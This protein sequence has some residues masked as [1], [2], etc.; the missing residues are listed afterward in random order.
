VLSRDAKRV[1]KQG[2]DSSLRYEGESDDYGLREDRKVRAPGRITKVIFSYPILFFF[3]IIFSGQFDA[4][5]LS[6]GVI[7]CALVAYFSS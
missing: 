3:W 2:R 4:F 7:S 1:F 5:H 6:L